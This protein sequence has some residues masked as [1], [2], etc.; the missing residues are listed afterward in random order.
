MR[1]PNIDEEGALARWLR[2][3]FGHKPLRAIANDIASDFLA[4]ARQV[5]PPVDATAI[6]RVRKIRRWRT[7]E[8]AVDGRIGVEGDGFVIETGPGPQVRRRFTLAHEIGHTIFF[9]L[10]GPMPHR[11]LSGARPEEEEAFCNMFA[12]ELLMP[13][14]WIFSA[15]EKG[16]DD[17]RYRCP[18]IV[19][20]N[21]AETFQ[22]SRRAMA[23]RLVEDLGVLQGIAMGA[24]WLGARGDLSQGPLGNWT[25]RLS[26]AATSPNVADALY[27]PS[28]QKRPRLKLPALEDVYKAGVAK[29]LEVPPGAVRL[30]NLRKILNEHAAVGEATCIWILPTRPTGVQLSSEPGEALRDHDLDHTIR[31]RYE[32][33]MFIPLRS[34]RYENPGDVH[35]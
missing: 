13:G 14:D 28:A 26:W 17:A 25:W 29:C 33:V 31:R 5:G 32:L 24:R 16:S 18:P 11:M 10:N 35:S 2:S 1:R 27:L 30:G 22:V 15:L 7:L 9:D 20:Q 19:I 3:R 34:N 8:T 6:F 12:S 4:I 23:R 21:L